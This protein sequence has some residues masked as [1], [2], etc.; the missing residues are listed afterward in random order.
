V[1]CAPGQ[2]VS[3]DLKA[4][5]PEG[6]PVTV[7]RRSG[8]IGTIEQGRFTVTIPAKDRDKIYRIHFIFSDG[9]GGY[10][11]KQ[12]KLLVT[13]DK[14]I[15][16]LGWS[17]TT[18]GP[19]QRAVKV[20]RAGRTFGFGRQPLDRQAKQMQGTFVFQPVSGAADLICRIPELG[21]GSDMAL[22][23]TNTLDGFSRHAGIGVFQGKISGVIKPR[24]QSWGTSTFQWDSKRPD[25]P[26]YFRLTWRDGTVVA[27]T[28]ADNET[29]EQVMTGKVGFYKECYAGLVYRGEPWTEGVCQ[30]LSPSE[31]GLPIKTLPAKQGQ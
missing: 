24:E 23:I 12:V 15:L 19:V 10:T 13:R 26:K 3:F 7:F 8:Q 4:R 16:P 22:M 20:R 2:T 11:G 5:D 18:L 27:Y 17:V 31:S 29:W 6:F 9:T 14:D 28:S 25:K 21:K 1:K 30:W